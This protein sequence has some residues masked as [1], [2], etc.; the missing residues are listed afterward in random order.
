M[1]DVVTPAAKGEQ[2]LLGIV[3]LLPSGLDVV[4]LKVDQRSALLAPPSVPL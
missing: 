4:D 3:S 2:V 1:K